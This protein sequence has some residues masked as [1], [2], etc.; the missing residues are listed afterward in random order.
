VEEAE[1]SEIK[2]KTRMEPDPGHSTTQNEILRE[3]ERV[4]KE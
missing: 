3:R 4:R 2:V 1:L